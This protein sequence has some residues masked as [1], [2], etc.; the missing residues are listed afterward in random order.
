M[1]SPTLEYTSLEQL[2]SFSCVVLAMRGILPPLTWVAVAL[3]TGPWELFVNPVIVQSLLRTGVIPDILGQL[4][5]C[6]RLGLSENQLT[7]KT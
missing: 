7:G 6:T 4:S 3:C 2:S 5:N 1:Q